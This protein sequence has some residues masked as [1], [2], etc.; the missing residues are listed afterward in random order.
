MCH[1]IY[2][3]SAYIYDRDTRVRRVNFCFNIHSQPQTNR[4]WASRSCRA[5]TWSPGSK[6]SRRPAPRLTR[7]KGRRRR[8]PWRGPRVSWANS[9]SKLVSI[10]SIYVF[11]TLGRFLPS[12]SLSLS[13]FQRPYTNVGRGSR[14]D[15]VL[16]RDTDSFPPRWTQRGLCGYAAFFPERW[17]ILRSRWMHTVL[18]SLLL[19]LDGEAG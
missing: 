6:C 15:E 1:R 9:P 18:L 13:R 17:L 16:S 11:Q 5:W 19:L 8:S 14:R 4:T 12:L 10:V 7:S 2:D 3:L